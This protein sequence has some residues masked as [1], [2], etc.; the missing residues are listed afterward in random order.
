M[1]LKDERPASY[2]DRIGR[3]YTRSVPPSRRKEFGQYL[4]PIQVARFMA[5]SMTFRVDDSLRVLD[6]GAGSGFSHAHCARRLLSAP[7]DGCMLNWRL[8]RPAAALQISW[9]LAWTMRGS[10]WSHAMSF[11]PRSV[12]RTDF[13][14]SHGPVLEQPQLRLLASERQ[15]TAFD[16]AVS[17]PPYFK[18][19][20]ADPRARA[21]RAVVHGQPNIYAL[22]MAVASAMLKVGGELAFITPRSYAAGPYFRLFRKMF[23]GKMKPLAVH[24]F[25]SRRDAF[26]RDDVLQENVILIARRAD[27]WS[28]SRNG[29]TVRVSASN[30]TDDLGQPSLRVVPLSEVLDLDGEDKVLRIPVTDQDVAAKRAIASWTSNLH[31]YGL[32]ISTG[33]V[34][35]FRSRPLLAT[36]GDISSTHAPL[37]WLRSVS[38]MRVRWPAGVRNKAE[39]VLMN[40]DSASLLVPDNNYVLVRRF[41]SKEQRRRL[42]AAPLIR[43]AMRS[44]Y[45]GFENHLNYLHRPGGS[46][47]AEEAYGLAALFNSELLDTIFRVSNGNTQVNA[48]EL[49]AMAL[50][51]MEAI[52]EIGRTL[53]LAGDPAAEVDDII[54]AVLGCRLKAV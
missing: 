17:N 11:Y 19:Q 43:G 30:G 34:I 13:L 47:S 52:R 24:L 22:F 5:K 8:T 44:R 15:T 39:Y 46:L 12:H 40:A 32:E 25:A 45:V 29:E 4:T 7:V 23:F 9:R 3:W 10:G 31:S 48:S 1:P 51:P 35:P 54:E 53:M 50:P 16:I 21:A 49:R 26:R 20:K 41:S 14:L 6:P 36:D 38:P 28:S 42:T 27:G 33:P 18:L 37:V 2:A